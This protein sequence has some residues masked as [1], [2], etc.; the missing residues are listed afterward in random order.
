MISQFYGQSSYYLLEQDF[1]V[2]EAKLILGKKKKKSTSN[3]DLYSDTLSQI[4]MSN[5]M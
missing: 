5:I 4:D 2:R 3:S 1:S